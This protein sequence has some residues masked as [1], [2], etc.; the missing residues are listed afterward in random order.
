MGQGSTALPV[1]MPARTVFVVVAHS[2]L[3]D[4]LG[5]FG[6]TSDTNNVSVSDYFCSLYELFLRVVMRPRMSDG[7]LVPW[8]LGLR[9]RNA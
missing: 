4:M 1:A 3:M 7:H 2:L 6:L 8:H 9:Y 5:S